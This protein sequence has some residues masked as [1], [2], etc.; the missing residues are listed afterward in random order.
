MNPPSWTSTTI[1]STPSRLSTGTYLFA[2]CA[3]SRNARPATPDGVTSCGVPSS[4]IPMNPT[5]TP[6]TVLIEYGGSR[7]LVCG[8]FGL[9]ELPLARLGALVGLA[10]LGL[11]L[12]SFAVLRERLDVRGALGGGDHHLD[13]RRQ[14]LE[15]R[16]RERVA[17]LAAV[18]RDGSRRAACAAAGPSPRRTRGCRP[19]SP[20]GPPAR[21]TRSSARR[22]TA[23]TAAAM[24]RSCRRRRRPV[25]SGSS[26]SGRDMWVAKNSAPPASTVPMRPL[27]PLGGSRLPW[28]SLNEAA[29]R[30]R[31]QRLLPLRPCVRSRT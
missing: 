30:T 28:K 3:S 7:F 15:L 27:E 1:V 24:R 20:A 8:A 25:C 2:V 4:V 5:F 9:D 23:P 21:A 22:G 11:R 29:A 26:P 10:G 6:P 31:A 13:V 14:V 18:G 17:V 16:A 12:E 19:T